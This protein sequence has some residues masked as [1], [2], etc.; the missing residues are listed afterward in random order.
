VN[1]LMADGSLQ[2][3]TDEIEA[4]IWRAMST[5]AGED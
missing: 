5:I 3:V 2:F 4:G 1:V